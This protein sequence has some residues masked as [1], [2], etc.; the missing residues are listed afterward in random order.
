MI[1]KIIRPDETGLSQAANALK[2]GRL[3]AFPTETVYGLG[4]DATSS[5]AVASIFDAK[6]RPTFN[7]LIIHT[8]DS[9]T[10]KTLGVF[11]EAASILARHF[12]PGPL[13][14][15]VPR[16]SD[17]PV[18]DLACAG[19]QTIALRVPAHEVAQKL[20]A[21]MDRPIAAPSANI[22]GRMSPTLAAH[23]SSS[24]EAS[25]AVA[26]ILD[27]GATDY[28]LESTIIGCF[29]DQVFL[30]RHGAVAQEDIEKLAGTLLLPDDDEKIKLSPGRLAAHYAPH[31]RLRLNIKQLQ[32]DEALL[33]FGRHHLRA[34]HMRNLS[35]SGDLREAAA[36]LFAMLHELDDCADKIAV[37]P[38]PMTGLGRAINDRLMRA[39]KI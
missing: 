22:S 2:H 12:W 20:L 1:S 6:Q 39:A 36:H 23:A 21:K 19:G 34:K 5:S 30:L 25:D 9:M 28:G 7:P 26:F 14:L 18:C 4:G 15:V 29:D 13:S 11:N 3:V 24:L 16:S 31:A 33:A 17:C 27:G 8:A 10:A 35:P 32:S 38:I 37:M